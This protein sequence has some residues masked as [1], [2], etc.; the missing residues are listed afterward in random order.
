MFMCSDSASTLTT[1]P[2]VGQPSKNVYVLAEWAFEC[3]LDAQKLIT[4]P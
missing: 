1:L 2:G 4:E 3:E